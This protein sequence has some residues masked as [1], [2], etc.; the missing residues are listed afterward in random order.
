MAGNTGQATRS[1]PSSIPVHNDRDMARHEVGLKAQQQLLLSE[2]RMNVRCGRY[3]HAIQERPYVETIPSKGGCDLKIKSN[4]HVG[5]CQSPL[6]ALI[7]VKGEQLNNCCYCRASH[8]GNVEKSRQRR[9]RHF[10]VL[11][12]YEYA[13]RVK[14]AAAL[15]DE[16]PPPRGH[17]FLNIPSH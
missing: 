9:S 16:P 4:R 11:T 8:Y 15:L 14:M 2:F 6:S 12:Y 17:A 3:V 1:G 7:K 13:P 5:Y 10:A